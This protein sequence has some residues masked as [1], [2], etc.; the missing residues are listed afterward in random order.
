MCVWKMIFVWG[1]LT[2]DYDRKNYCKIVHRLVSW[3]ARDHHSRP[4]SVRTYLFF[5]SFFFLFCVLAML[6]FSRSATREKLNITLSLSL[7]DDEREREREREREGEKERWEKLKEKRESARLK[8]VDTRIPEEH[9]YRRVMRSR[10]WCVCWRKGESREAAD[11]E[12]TTGS[13]RHAAF[14]RSR[15]GDAVLDFSCQGVPKHFKTYHSW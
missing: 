1:L 10:A 3:M 11:E 5:P 4:K 6:F 8:R 14:D 13:C 7:W 12:H 15:N 9:A 2:F